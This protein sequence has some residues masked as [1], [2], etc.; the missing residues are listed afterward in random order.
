MADQRVFQL[1]TPEKASLDRLYL[2]PFYD[3]P[4]PFRYVHYLVSTEISPFPPNLS[5]FNIPCAPY[6]CRR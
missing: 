5:H 2:Y 4:F 6:L 3:S 1:A